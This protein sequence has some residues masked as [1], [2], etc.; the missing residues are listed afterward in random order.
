MT[1]SGD[2]RGK[3]LDQDGFFVREGSLERVPA[4]FAP[5]VAELTARLATRFAPDRLVSSYLYGSVPRG[6]AV[7]GV[8]DLDALLVLRTGPGDADRAAARAVE[9]ELDAAFP[10]IDGAGFLLIAED[11]LLGDQERY[12]M[13]WFV[14]CLC[15]PLGGPDVTAALP[16]YRP[17][18]LLA[19][20]TNGDL[21]RRL[22]GMRERAAAAA[23]REERDRLTRGITRNLVR[24]GFTLV[25]P[26]WGG[27]TSD[28]AESAEVFAHYYPAHA[29]Q[30]RAA[31]RAA[32]HPAAYPELLDDLLNGLAPWLADT[33][34]A[35]HGAK[36]LPPQGP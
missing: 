8:S 34:L 23:T 20:E 2:S 17:T 13:A 36:A 9:A 26:R 3:G 22:P 6:T 21:H 1:T 33:Y 32:R 11:R 30:M 15:T 24:T 5:V 19:R 16:R 18:S 27:W 14:A 7:P 35:V 10:Q 25:M 29:D 12:D 31:A 28:L 4:P